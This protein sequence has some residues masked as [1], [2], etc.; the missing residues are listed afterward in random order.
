M[1]VRRRS[2]CTQTEQRAFGGLFV[3]ARRILPALR[4][5]KG[6][7]WFSLKTSK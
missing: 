7:D 1:E 2:C 6:L 3:L 4:N 5:K